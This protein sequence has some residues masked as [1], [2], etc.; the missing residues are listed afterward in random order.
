MINAVAKAVPWF[1]GGSADLSPS[2]KT[3]IN[4]GGSFERDTPGGRNMHYGIREH[5]WVLS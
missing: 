2:T 5:G 3:T 1:V 4:D